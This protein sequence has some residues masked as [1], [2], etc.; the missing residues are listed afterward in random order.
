MVS[1]GEDRFQCF[2]STYCSFPTI[3]SV[4][5]LS[6]V[7][8]GGNVL[9][10]IPGGDY[11]PVTGLDLSVPGSIAT[12]VID[13]VDSAFRHWMDPVDSDEDSSTVAAFETTDCFTA[14]AFESD[15]INGK[16]FNIDGT[17]EMIWAG[18]SADHFVGYHGPF[19]RQ[20]F[21]ID[22][23]AANVVFSG[24]TEGTWVEDDSAA[25]ANETVVVVGD[26][27]E[28]VTTPIEDVADGIAAPSV[29]G[30]DSVSEEVPKAASDGSTNN[31]V[32]P[33]IQIMSVAVFLG[34]TTL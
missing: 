11:S 12:Y 14:I 34:L 30:G 13:D 8:A 27:H 3:H 23:K 28:S 29:A 10:A 26:D 2:L 21:T 4:L 1:E 7:F 15:H 25:T 32:A 6:H 22:W 17:D 24:A 18:N 33:T 19:S 5:L 9:L 31:N 20:R 16:A